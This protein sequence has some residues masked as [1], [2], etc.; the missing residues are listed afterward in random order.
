MTFSI[1]LSHF[2]LSVRRPGVM[3]G[4]LCTLMPVPAL[5][6]PAAVVGEIEVAQNR[7]TGELPGARRAL[8]ISDPVH[9]D[10]IVST[11]ADASTRLRFTD[12]SDL[13]L[14]ASARI[15]LNAALFGAE[16]GSA[17]RL[18]RGAMQFFSGDGPKGSYQIRT[19]VGTIGLRGTG[20]SV[21][22]RGGL[23]Y[24]TL[25]EGEAR[26]CPTW[27][28]CRELRVPCDFV[29]LGRSASE[30]RP[31]DASTPVFANLCEGA[32]CGP[33]I[34]Q[35]GRQNGVLN[36]DPVNPNAGGGPAGNDGSSG[37]N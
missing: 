31:S 35:R 29:E 32:A 6:A 19:P 34:C 24:V 7:V 21:V 4:L 10:E 2:L 36:V 37:R 12:R 28:A 30:P 33:P 15:R 14:G 3:F 23:T 8:A 27:G 18:T 1:G 13:R 16:G 17:L 26:V 20:V 25:L 5:A 22:I 9:L 11:A